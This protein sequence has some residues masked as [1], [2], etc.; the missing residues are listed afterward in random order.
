MANSA[1][2]KKV[3]VSRVI[4]IAL[5]VIGGLTVLDNT[6][7]L[8]K[9]LGRSISSTIASHRWNMVVIK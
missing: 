7:R 4:M 9:E 1:S 8:G 3:K 2:K 5:M 6:Y